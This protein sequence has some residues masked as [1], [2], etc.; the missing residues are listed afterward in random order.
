MTTK[1]KR[2]VAILVAV[3]TIAVTAAG[4]LADSTPGVKPS[5]P[6]QAEVLDGMNFQRALAGVPGLT[7]SPKLTFLATLW[8]AVMAQYVGFTHQNLADHLYND[9]DY[10]NYNTLGENILVGP[11]SMTAAQMLGSWM[12]SPAHRN[13]ILSRNFN[14]AGVGYYRAADGR[15]WVCV[16]FGG[17]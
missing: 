9:P 11:G 17:I 10:A 8:A 12:G 6:L 7:N 16:D 14:I 4:C 1:L 5:D 2:R 3:A 13:N 15:L